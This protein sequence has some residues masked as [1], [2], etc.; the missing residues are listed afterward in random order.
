MLFNNDRNEKLNIVW[1]EPPDLALH[2]ISEY[3]NYKCNR[4][5]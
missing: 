3:S 1:M 4:S 5:V 2:S